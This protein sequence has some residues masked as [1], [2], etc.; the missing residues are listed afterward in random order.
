MS[1]A[2]P[3]SG[4]ASLTRGPSPRPSRRRPGRG[5]RPRSARV[6]SRVPTTPG[7]P[8]SRATIAECESRP[9][10]SVTI[11]PSSGRRM[12]NAS[13]VD[14][15]TRTS[16]WTIRSNSAGPEMRRAGPSY[17]PRLA[18]NPRSEVLLVLGLGAAEERFAARSR[19]PASAGRYPGAAPTGPA[20]GGAGGPSVSGASLALWPARYSARAASSSADGPPEPASRSRISSRLASTE[21]RRA[22]R[23]ALAP[24]AGGRRR[25]TRAASAPRPRCR[26]RRR[27]RRG[28]GTSAAPRRAARRTPRG[29]PRAPCRGR[30]RSARRHRRRRC[31]SLRRRSASPA[32]ARPAAR[33]RS[34]RRCRSRRGAGT[35]PGR[36]SRRPPRPSRRRW[37]AAP[38][39]SRRDRRPTRAAARA[40]GSAAIAATSRSSCGRGA[41]RHGRRAR[42]S[43]SSSAGGSPVQS[44]TCARKSPVG[45]TALAVKRMCWVIIAAWW[46]RQRSR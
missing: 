8:Y 40:S 38:R 24:R 15:V 13:V 14:S 1:R 41:G 5:S 31:S 45:T 28:A 42:I 25:A 16:P 44:P 22:R 6:A 27:A 43:P 17:T 46:S 19:S 37:S 29:A 11:A 32:A 23:S 3:T 18:A 36:G 21:V 9:P 20:G 26:C 34:A 35:R 33:A 39:A 2:P 10:L 4:T 7:I 12:L 30:R